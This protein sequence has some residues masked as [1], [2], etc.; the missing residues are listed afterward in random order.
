MPAVFYMGHSIH[1]NEPSGSNAALLS[2]YFLAAAQGK[3][4]EEYLSNTIILLDPSF[5]PDGCNA[6]AVG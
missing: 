2:A 3:K 6:S 4:I 5:N 1:G